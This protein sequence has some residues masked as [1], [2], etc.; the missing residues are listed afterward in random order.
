MAKKFAG[1]KQEAMEKKIL[2]ALGYTG[3]MDQKS[4]NKLVI[5]ALSI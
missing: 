2:P 1:F 4:V 5:E 3:P